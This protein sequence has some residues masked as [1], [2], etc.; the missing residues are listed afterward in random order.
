[1]EGIQ[2]RLLLLLEHLAMCRKRQ[3]LNFIQVKVEG[4][5]V[6]DFSVAS[7]NILADCHMK[8]EW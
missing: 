8:P 3:I 2:L 4:P 1:M 5:A 7:Y 6:A